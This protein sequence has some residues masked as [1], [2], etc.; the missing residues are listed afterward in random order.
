MSEDQVEYAKFP[1]WR[2]HP[3]LDPV[4]VNNEEEEKAL[5][6]GYVA[7]QITDEERADAA[8][9]AATEAESTSTPRS[10]R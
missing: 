5:P 9:K 10:R 2:Y 4:I 8:A 6:P 1:G 7:H 3:T